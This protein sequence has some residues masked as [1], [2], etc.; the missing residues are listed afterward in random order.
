MICK[1][2]NP[3]LLDEECYCVLNDEELAQVKNYILENL[4]S[5]K[6]HLD[7]ITSSSE[8]LEQLKFGE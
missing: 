4:V 1:E 2:E 7:E 8:F 6:E 5:I 3:N